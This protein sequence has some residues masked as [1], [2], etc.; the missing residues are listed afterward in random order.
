MAIHLIE[1]NSNTASKKD[2]HLEKWDW[3]HR[4]CPKKRLI[5][6][7]DLKLEFSTPCANVPHSSFIQSVILGIP[8]LDS[9][10]QM[11]ATR[12]CHS[13]G[14]FYSNGEETDTK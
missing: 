11:G 1:A 14:V 3:Q 8:M 5:F 13:Q 2:T 9:W 4:A 6:L 10:K 12:K 7:E